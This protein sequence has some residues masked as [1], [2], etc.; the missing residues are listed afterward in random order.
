MQICR[1]VHVVSNPKLYINVVPNMPNVMKINAIF[2]LVLACSVPFTLTACA[3]FQTDPPA[4]VQAM[5]LDCV[6]RVAIQNWYQSQLA[7]PRQ[8]FQKPAD[9]ESSQAQIRY[10]I[11]HLRYHCQ[12]V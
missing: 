11:W 12:P 4:S 7:V 2:K 8:P 3:T 1:S 6:N 9:Y 5:P 10:R